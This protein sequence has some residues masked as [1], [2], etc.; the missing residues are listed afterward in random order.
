MIIH[1][2]FLKMVKTVYIYTF[3]CQMNVHDSEKML[4]VLQKEGYSQANDPLLADLIIFNTC[5]IRQ[6][7]E[8]KFY[9]EL[10]RF[11]SYKKKKA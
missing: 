8:Q 10:G 7:A 2:K 1:V 9:S 4:G 3:G 11:K 5:S 6:K